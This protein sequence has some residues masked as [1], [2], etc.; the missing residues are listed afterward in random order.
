MFIQKVQYS[1]ACEGLWFQIDAQKILRTPQQRSMSM[2]ERK[3]MCEPRKYS[4]I[5]I[6]RLEKNDKEEF[7]A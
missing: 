2:K 7:E 3:S 6:L 1:A 4:L 5:S